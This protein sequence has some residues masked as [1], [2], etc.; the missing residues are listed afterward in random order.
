MSQITSL[1]LK[2]RGLSSFCISEEIFLVVKIYR[3]ALFYYLSQSLLLTTFYKAER[4][5][6]DSITPI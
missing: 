4:I 5:P 6:D 1:A 2:K 3:L